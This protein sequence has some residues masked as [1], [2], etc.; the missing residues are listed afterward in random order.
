MA[1][2]FFYKLVQNCKRKFLKSVVK[3]NL[4]KKKIRKNKKIVCKTIDGA[5]C[6]ETL[7]TMNK[8]HL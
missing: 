4:Y 6:K 7:S 1:K 5:D 8:H 2:N 3:E